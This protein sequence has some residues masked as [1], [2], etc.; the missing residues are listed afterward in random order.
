MEATIEVGISPLERHVIANLYWSQKVHIRCDDKNSE[1]VTIQ[2]GVRQ[3]CILSP[4][5]FNLYSER[6]IREA[7]TQDDGI[8]INRSRISNIQYA[9][10]YG[11]R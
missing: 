3:G 8:K 4:N 5:L 7:V 11:T 1:E 6:I 2:R 9:V 10:Q